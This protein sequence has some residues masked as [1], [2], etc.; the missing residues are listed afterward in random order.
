MIIGPQKWKISVLKHMTRWAGGINISKGEISGL[1]QAA[2]VTPAQQQHRGYRFW[3]NMNHHL[4]IILQI[5][6]NQILKAS[7]MQVQVAA[8]AVPYR[9]GSKASCEGV[10]YSKGGLYLC[11]TTVPCIEF[12]LKSGDQLR[13]GTVHDFLAMILMKFAIRQGEMNITI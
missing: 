12:D 2:S 10:D 1:Y 6:F 5:T 3:L 4:S 7:L 11:R 13:G 9:N 8:V